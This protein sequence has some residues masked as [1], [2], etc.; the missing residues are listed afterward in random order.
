MSRML[1]EVIEQ[2]GLDEITVYG[3]DVTIESVDF[4]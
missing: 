1:R 4:D 3:D 2:A